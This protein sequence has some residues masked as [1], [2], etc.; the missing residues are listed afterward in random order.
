MRILF[1]IVAYFLCIIFALP[2]LPV[3]LIVHFVVVAEKRR[4]K[5]REREI[6]RGV[7]RALSKKK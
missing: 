3:L 7:S 1:W 4:S 5:Q 6:E 2:A